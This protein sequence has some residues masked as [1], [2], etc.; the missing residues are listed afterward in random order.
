MMGVGVGKRLEKQSAP[1]LIY[2]ALFFFFISAIT[3]VCLWSYSLHKLHH[4][5]R[6]WSFSWFDDKSF[7]ESPAT[8]QLSWP[9]GSYSGLPGTHSFLNEQQE[10][11]L[12]RL[13]RS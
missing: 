13:L 4:E 1:P 11:A 8:Q 12:L 9:G 3:F 7:L 10:K 5:V 6:G 2:S